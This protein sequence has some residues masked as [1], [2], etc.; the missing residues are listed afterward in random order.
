[1][2]AQAANPEDPEKFVGLW[3]EFL[4]ALTEGPVADID[5]ALRSGYV[6]K[7]T[8]PRRALFEPDY[9]GMAVITPKALHALLFA[10]IDWH[11]PEGELDPNE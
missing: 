10:F 9:A 1:M 6:L 3:T 5:R 7:A 11:D 4:D 8:I 2:V